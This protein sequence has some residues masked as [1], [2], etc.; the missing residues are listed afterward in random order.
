[1]DDPYF[2]MLVRAEARALLVEVLSQVADTL[3]RQAALTAQS[4]H[5]STP[6][7]VSGAIRT[8][9]K[10]L[11]SFPSSDQRTTT[12]PRPRSGTSSIS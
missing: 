5:P 11:T 10:S 2:A 4:G 3:D 1:M 7:S 9:V 12:P 8:A 6:P